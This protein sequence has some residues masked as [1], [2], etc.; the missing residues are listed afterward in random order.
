[1]SVNSGVRAPVLTI[2]PVGDDVGVEQIT[3]SSL[4]TS[5]TDVTHQGAPPREGDVAT[6]G[7]HDPG[8][9]SVHQDITDYIAGL[10]RNNQ[11][12]SQAAGD[13]LDDLLQQCS[14]GEIGTGRAGLGL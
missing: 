1:M 2:P 6:S 8:L 4:D 12:L 9:T 10:N 7:A 13:G 14:L 11:R 5:T 3:D